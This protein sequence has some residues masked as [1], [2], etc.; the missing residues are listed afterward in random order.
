MA[1]LLVC[2]LTVVGAVISWQT[3]HAIDG[4]FAERRMRMPEFAKK[5]AETTDVDVLKQRIRQ[6][7]AGFE[8][9][10]HDQQEMLRL[11]TGLMIGFGLLS[12]V[13]AALCMKG[14]NQCQRPVAD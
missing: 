2:C 7:E 12:G 1:N 8:S 14:I 13:N 11:A 9:H 4:F 3:A 6:T 10:L 5:L